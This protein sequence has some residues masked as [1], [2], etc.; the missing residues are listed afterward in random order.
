MMRPATTPPAGDRLPAGEAGLRRPPD[1][2]DGTVPSGSVRGT[3]PSGPAPSAAPRRRR[4]T[5]S[6]AYALAGVAV[7][8]LVAATAVIFRMPFERAASLA[9]V[10]VITAGATVFL[11]VL[12]TKIALDSLRRQRHPKRIVAA[13]VGALALLALVSFFL[14]APN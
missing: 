14:P 4:G 11:V 5:R 2:A 9:P 13:G 10:I 7:A 6:V 8:S 12:W 1:A 3:I